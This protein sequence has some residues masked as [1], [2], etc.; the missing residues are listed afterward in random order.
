MFSSRANPS[1]NNPTVPKVRG[2]KDCVVGFAQLWKPVLCG[3]WGGCTVSR[4]QATVFLSGSMARQIRWPI[5]N[6]T[7]H[8][9]RMGHNDVDSYLHWHFLVVIEYLWQK[10]REKNS[11]PEWVDWWPHLYVRTVWVRHWVRRT[12]CICSWPC[13]LLRLQW[14]LQQHPSVTPFYGVETVLDVAW[15]CRAVRPTA[16]EQI[17]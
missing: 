2:S 15:K 12:T 13:N 16:L 3:E 17:D 1:T 6:S 5:Q 9:L 4:N 7:V 11:F 10:E 14:G 8:I